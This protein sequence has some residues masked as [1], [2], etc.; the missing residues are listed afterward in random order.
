MRDFS[1]TCSCALN[2]AG[3]PDQGENFPPWQQGFPS[4]MP[5]NMPY[6]NQPNNFSMPPMNQPNNNFS[7]M[8]NNNFQPN[9]FS[10]MN[11]NQP[12]NFSTPPMSNNMPMS[13]TAMN[14]QSPT[15]PSFDDLSR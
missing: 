7:P 11:M 13:P 14:M 3:A 5:D 4:N 12:N 6:M 2:I 1:H 10:P 8:N 9:N 15:Q